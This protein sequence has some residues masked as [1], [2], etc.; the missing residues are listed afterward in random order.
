MEQIFLYAVYIAIGWLII[1]AIFLIASFATEIGRTIPVRK[2]SLILGQIFEL[3]T[4]IS[5]LVFIIPYFSQLPK[6]YE[7]LVLP[8]TTHIDSKVRARWMFLGLISNIASM[9]WAKK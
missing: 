1:P 3:I 9:L 5:I 7:D 8:L 2:K 6:I 4:F